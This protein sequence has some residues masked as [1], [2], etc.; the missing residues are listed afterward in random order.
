MKYAILVEWFDTDSETNEM[1]TENVAVSLVE[2]TKRA[3][4][5]VSIFRGMPM[6]VVDHARIERIKDEEIMWR[7]TEQT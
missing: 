1:Y 4:Q 5:I 7:M 6:R 3:E 2:A